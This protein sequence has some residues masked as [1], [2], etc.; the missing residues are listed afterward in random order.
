VCT[1]SNWVSQE[2]TIFSL[3]FLALVEEI[4]GEEAD[5]EE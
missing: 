5:R 1:H 4:L 2:G 3:E